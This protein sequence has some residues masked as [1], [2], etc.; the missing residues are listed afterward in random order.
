MIY[1]VPTTKYDEGKSVFKLTGF[2]KIFQLS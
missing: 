1:S 2:N